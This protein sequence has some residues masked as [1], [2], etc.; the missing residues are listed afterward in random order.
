MDELPPSEVKKPESPF[1]VI[2]CA[3]LVIGI[4]VGAIYLIGS[5]NAN[6]QKS[7]ESVFT[8]KI[9][10]F[11]S[12]FNEG[13]Y[14][15]S[16]VGSPYISGKILALD[17]EKKKVDAFQFE[18]PKELRAANIDD[19]GTILFISH[20]LEQS[21]SYDA[22]YGKAPI[23]GYSHECKLYLYD[24]KEKKPIK[25]DSFITFPPD[26]ISRRMEN[27]SP[28]YADPP[29]GDMNKFLEQTPKK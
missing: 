29:N 8:V 20:K 11:I 26:K 10:E 14:D 6:K 3:L 17:L 23:P 16:K 18:M 27:V 24:L 28:E 19:I 1:A 21:K 12:L 22:G 2:G 15:S 7:A 9:P 25:A 4:F 5:F 13:D